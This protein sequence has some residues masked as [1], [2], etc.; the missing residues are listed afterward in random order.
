MTVVR[1][2]RKHITAIDPNL[3]LEDGRPIYAYDDNGNPI[4]HKVG[5]GVTIYANLENVSGG[6]GG[7]SYNIAKETPT[8]VNDGSNRL[9]VLAHTPIENSDSIYVNGV[10]QDIGDDYIF[11]TVTE[12]EFA[13]APPS[14]SKI[15]ATYF[16]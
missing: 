3:V 11:L 12:I 4:S 9:F 14:G 16:Y 10:F 5:D 6:G 1:L 7:S 8:G 2:I 13:I 15:R